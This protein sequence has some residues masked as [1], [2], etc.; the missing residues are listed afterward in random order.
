MSLLKKIA[1]LIP[2]VRNIKT[3]LHNR[4]IRAEEFEAANKILVKHN[5]E[6]TSDVQFMK[7]QLA[8]V[9]GLKDSAIS[10]ETSLAANAEHLQGQL[11]IVKA[12]YEKLKSNFDEME[13]QNCVLQLA[14]DDLLRINAESNKTTELA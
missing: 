10:A 9:L 2:S 13:T 8:K 4:R 6:L 3:D 14:N 7:E 1:L 11:S 5:K 12:K